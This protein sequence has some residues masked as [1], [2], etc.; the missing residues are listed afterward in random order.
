MGSQF[1]AL[2]AAYT[3]ADIRAAARH[4][5]VTLLWLT[6]AAALAG[7]VYAVIDQRLELPARSSR[8]VTRVALV[9]AVL[10]VVAV[11]VAFFA[12]V[13]HPVRW[14]GDEWR[15]FKHSPSHETAATHFGSLGSNRY[16]FW[17]VALNEFEHHPL[18]GIGDRGFGPRISFSAEAARLRCAHTRS[19]ST[20]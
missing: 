10:A 7:V 17:R 4:A 20:P 1:D 12:T 6:A 3:S 16:D 2:T 5:G 19:S 9:A 18:A 11:P 13:D 8:I 15:A 14:A